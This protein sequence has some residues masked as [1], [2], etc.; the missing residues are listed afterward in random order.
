MFQRYFRAYQRSPFFLSL[1]LKLHHY[2][3]KKGPTSSV[4][5]CFCIYWCFVVYIFLLFT[6]SIVCLLQWHKYRSSTGVANPPL[7]TVCFFTFLQSNWSTTAKA[8]NLFNTNLCSQ[9]A[10]YKPQ[11]VQQ[12]TVNT[13]TG[14][15]IS[16]L[17]IVLTR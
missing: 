7:H 10:T 3:T 8:I 1:P 11:E 12:S 6:I 5:V 9:Y 2:T 13:S 15:H 16:A 14:L 17:C 4:C